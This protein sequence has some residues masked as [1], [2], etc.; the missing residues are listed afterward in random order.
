M[1]NPISTITPEIEKFIID[2]YN[3][4]K[5]GAQAISDRLALPI[6]DGGLNVKISRAP[7]GKKITKLKSDGVL[8]M[9]LIKIEKL[10]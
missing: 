8:N 3:K 1:A 7:I 4:E 6:K 5:I 10:L 9:F 2:L